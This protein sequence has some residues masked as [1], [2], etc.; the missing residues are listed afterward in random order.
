MENMD[1]LP[2]TAP[3]LVFAR[4]TYMPY[5]KHVVSVRNLVTHLDEN[6]HE[7]EARSLP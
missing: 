2:P 6:S 5:I 4:E 1:L 7:Q 3:S